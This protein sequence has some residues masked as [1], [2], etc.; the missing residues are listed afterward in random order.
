MAEKKEIELPRLFEPVHLVM[1]KHGAQIQELKGLLTAPPSEFVDDIVLYRFL[2]GYKFDI[3]AA[4]KAAN[5]MLEWRAAVGAD[6]AQR[7]IIAGN[8]KQNQLPHHLKLRASYPHNFRHKTDKLGQPLSIA[9][10]GQTDVDTLLKILSIEEM[11]EYQMYHLLSVAHDLAE[12]TKETGTVV[13]RCQ[14]FDLSGLGLKHSSR[15]V[16]QYSRISTQMAQ[17]YFP[18]LMG[19]SYICNAPGLFGAIW[20]IVKSWL[21]PTTVEKIKILSPADTSRVLLEHVA[22]ENL[23]AM[24]GGGCNCEGGCVLSME[25]EGLSSGFTELQIAARDTKEISS[26]LEADS[27]ALWR[28]SSDKNISFGAVFVPQGGERVVVVPEAQVNSHEKQQV[29]EFRSP[30]KGRMVYTFSNSFSYLRGK[31]LKYR[32]SV[33]AAAPMDANAEPAAA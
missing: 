27:L 32:L 3:E 26:E 4:G 12:L 14:I 6:E 19:A 10:P 16:M 9:M 25:V 30:S 18:E 23:P 20:S 7:K 28:F 22:A 1:Q 5:A 13:R 24:F 29:G 21:N 15:A 11:T 33:E 8:L 17:K 31:T 2:N